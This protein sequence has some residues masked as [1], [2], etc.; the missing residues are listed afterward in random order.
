MR[1]RLLVI[2]A[3]IG[4]IGIA[5]LLTL[6]SYSLELMHSVVVNYVQQKAPEGYARE[7]VEEVFSERFERAK[8]QG[9]E[10]AYAE[11]LNQIFQRIEKTQVLEKEEVDDL[12]K[13]VEITE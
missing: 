7:R 13:E 2:M 1:K 9:R 11:Q 6:K 12:L 3:C 5:A 8:A 10:D 4:L